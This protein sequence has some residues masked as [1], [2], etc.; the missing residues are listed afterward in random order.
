MY[1][2]AQVIGLTCQSKT[3]RQLSKTRR[4][5]VLDESQKTKGN[6]L[7]TKHQKSCKATCE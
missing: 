7:T 4:P 1:S 2:T 5:C 6:N 3:S